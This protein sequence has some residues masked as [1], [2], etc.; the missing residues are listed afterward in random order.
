[1][2]KE[3]QEV[4]DDAYNRYRATI[5]K[6][7][8]EDT[9]ELRKWATVEGPGGNTKE[10]FINKCKTD[11]KFAQNWGLKIEEREL[12]LE[13]RSIIAGSNH[14]EVSQNIKMFTGIDEDH[15]LHKNLD[16]N[17]IPTK[18]I[19]ITYKETIIESYE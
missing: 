19:T 4:L 6:E 17:N 2:N 14:N 7:F 5:I 10:E 12:S 8:Y 1:M 9:K 3:Q 15:T 13:E 16:D 11:S 18:L